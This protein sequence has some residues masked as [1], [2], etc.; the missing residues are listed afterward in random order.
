MTSNG[1]YH[2]INE[3][4]KNIKTRTLFLF[5]YKFNVILSEKKQNS[6]FKKK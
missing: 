1:L 3:K 6:P 2:S 5:I 4:N